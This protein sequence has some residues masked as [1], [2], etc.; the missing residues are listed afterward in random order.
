[1]FAIRSTIS[2]GLGATAVL[3]MARS[4]SADNKT[5]APKLTYFDVR[6]LAEVSRI[7]CKVGQL[8]FTDDRL[9]FG[10]IK[11]GKPVSPIFFEGKN[12][13]LFDVNMG[14]IPIVEGILINCD[15]IDKNM[16]VISGIYCS[17]WY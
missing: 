3:A 10:G 7:I 8:E 14:R 17:E 11:D 12:N 9:F 2:R 4:A 1:M 13:G 16:L 6:A 15:C 5:T